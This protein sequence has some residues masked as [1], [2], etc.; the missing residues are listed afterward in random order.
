M[1][2]TADGSVTYKA[3]KNAEGGVVIVALD[4]VE[5]GKLTASEKKQFAAQ[6]EQTDRISLQNSLL[7]ALRAKAKIEIN[8]AFINQEQ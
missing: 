7:N 1:K 4:N 8:D 6:L 2:K 3:A 5:D